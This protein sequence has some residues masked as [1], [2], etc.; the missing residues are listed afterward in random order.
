MDCM[1]ADEIII[2]DLLTLTIILFILFPL[3]LLLSSC[4]TDAKDVFVYRVIDGDTIVTSAGT[5]R[6]IG[7][8][9]PEKSDCGYEEAKQELTTLVE[10]KTV[11]L[12]TDPSQ[13]DRDKYGRYLR[14]VEVDK[15]DVAEDLFRLLHV[16]PFPWFASARLKH[17][18]SLYDSSAPLRG[19]EEL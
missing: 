1:E 14:Y 3:F 2:N 18:E 15:K 13:D 10:G 19:C 11:D 9:A 5:V 7:I 8:D 17:Y 16:K 6:L 4:V 12:V